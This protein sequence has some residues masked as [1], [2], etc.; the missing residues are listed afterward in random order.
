MITKLQSIYTV[1]L[2]KR[3][4]LGEINGLPSDGH[5]ELIKFMGRLLSGGD[6]SRVISW[7]IKWG[8]GKEYRER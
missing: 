6:G 5:I 4:S 7:Q 1:S 8:R 3:R 2:V